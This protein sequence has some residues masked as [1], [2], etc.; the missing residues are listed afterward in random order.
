MPLLRRSISYPENIVV[1][2]LEITTPE[3]KEHKN[4]LLKFKLT[5]EVNKKI[6]VLDGFVFLKWGNLYLVGRNEKGLPLL[7]IFHHM[8]VHPSS[9]EDVEWMRGNVFAG[10]GDEDHKSY[11]IGL[12][13]FDNYLNIKMGIYNINNKILVKYH[14]NS[15]QL[16]CED[17]K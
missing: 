4:R 10:I 5:T 15:L 13:R 7:I 12:S 6:E 8:N 1:G 2:K 9:G 11:R 14:N 3:N 16:I 17:K